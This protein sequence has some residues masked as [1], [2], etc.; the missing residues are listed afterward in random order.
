VLE[1]LE[2]DEL[3]VDELEELGEDEVPEELGVDDEELEELGELE[4]GVDDDP[5]ALDELGELELGL[6]A[7]PLVLE[8]SLLE[9]EP[10]IEPEGVDDEAPLDEPERDAPGPPALSQPYRPATATA[11]GRA[12]TTVFLSNFIR[13][14]HLRV[15]DGHPKKA[16]NRPV[17]RSAGRQPLLFGCHAELYED[18]SVHGS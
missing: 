3:G 7:E 6:L 13:S 1:S 10:D 8:E 4:L 2:P 18:R 15:G 5:D 9:L 17:C 11:M 14:S 16:N 12:M